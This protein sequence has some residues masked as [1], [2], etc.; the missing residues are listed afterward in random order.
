MRLLVL[1][2]NSNKVTTESIFFFA[3]LRLYILNYY[4]G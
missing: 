4:I 1:Y 3:Y 2:V